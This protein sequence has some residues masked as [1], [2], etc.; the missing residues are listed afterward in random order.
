MIVRRAT[1]GPWLDTASPLSAKVC[2]AIKL[3]GYVGVIRYLPLPNNNSVYDLH[4]AETND[5]LKV[6]LE[7]GACQHVRGQPPKS[8]LW[9]PAEYDGANDARFAANYA[10]AE[11]GLP[12]AMHLCQDLEAVDGT[13]GDAMQYSTDWGKAMQ[14][15]GFP[16]ELYVGY[17]VPLSGAQLYGL[18]HTSYGSDAG[19]RPVAVRGTAWLQGGT[20]VIE[21]VTFDK[22]VIRLDELGETPWICSNGNGNA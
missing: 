10:R 2:A 3:A 16:A 1:P 7:L 13:S 14:A 11:A 20:V 18:P 4:F 8:P 21:G 12:G 15:C 19:N 6:G 5:I 9:R 17:A 22:G